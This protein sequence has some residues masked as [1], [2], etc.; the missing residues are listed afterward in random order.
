MSALP[1]SALGCCA[2]VVLF[3]AE[4]DVKDGDIRA[5]T[6][7]MSALPCS[8]L[9]CCVAVVLFPAEPLRHCP[10]NSRKL[11]CCTGPERRGRR[12]KRGCNLVPGRPGGSGTGA[13]CHGSQGVRS[14]GERC[15][16]IAACRPRSKL[17]GPHWCVEQRAFN[18][19]MSCCDL[20]L[21]SKKYGLRCG[22]A[23][24]AM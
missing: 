11:F 1:C 24:A 14:G 10:G 7:G 8:A 6:S 18:M 23:A 5:G 9:S 17:V 2:D 12:H 21:L 19:A 4:P 13:I 20:F 22:Q 3:P 15:C 16:H